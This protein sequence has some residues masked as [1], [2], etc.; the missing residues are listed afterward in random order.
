MQDPQVAAARDYFQV[1]GPILQG[2]FAGYPE[3]PPAAS[4]RRGRGPTRRARGIRRLSGGGL[5]S[6]R[7][8]RHFKKTP[9][10]PG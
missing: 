1:S 2:E 7:C 8:R 10:M 4:D 6:G 5:L 3:K 9:Q